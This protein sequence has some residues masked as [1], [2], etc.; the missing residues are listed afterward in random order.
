MIYAALFGKV[1]KLSKEF[2]NIYPEYMDN[3]FYDFYTIMM[4]TQISANASS[5][6]DYSSTDSSGF[7]SLGGG[8]GSFG[9][10]VGGGSR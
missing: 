3:S 7:S 1:K 2:K 9:G 8:G 4:I 6:Y 10:G 5:T